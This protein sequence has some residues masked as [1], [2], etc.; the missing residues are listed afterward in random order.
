MTYHQKYAR[1]RK[2]KIFASF[3]LLVST[4]T[5]VTFVIIAFLGNQVGRYTVQL[6]SNNTQLTMD[7]SRD[8]TRPTTLL[9]AEN[10]ERIYPIMADSL[11]DDEEIDNMAGSHNG[12]YRDPLDQHVYSL[13]FAYT[14]FIKNVGDTPVDYQIWMRLRTTTYDSPDVIP[15]EEYVRVRIYENRDDDDMI[16]KTHASRTLAKRT[17]QLIYKEDNEPEYRECI[18]RTSGDNKT[19]LADKPINAERAEEFLNLQEITRYD[20]TYFPPEAVMRYTIVIWLEGDD[21]DCRGQIPQNASLEFSM[22]ISSFTES[23]TSSSSQS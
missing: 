23:D 2:R 18:A 8:F 15:L 21:P 12:E 6:K 4:V 19:C 9:R 22:D 20:V 3:M 5:L 10:V 1:R 7:Y 11:P 14:F 16:E 17:N 13:Y